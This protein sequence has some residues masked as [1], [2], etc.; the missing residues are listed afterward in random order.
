[1]TA[2]HKIGRP[3]KRAS[4]QL[5]LDTPANAQT[6]TQVVKHQADDLG[7]SQGAKKQRSETSSTEKGGKVKST[8]S[9]AEHTVNQN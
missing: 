8:A 4:K 1:M 3:G 6:T 7:K 2:G 9:Q 5:E